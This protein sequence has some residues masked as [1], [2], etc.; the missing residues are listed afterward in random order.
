[1]HA[2]FSSPKKNSGFD[3]VTHAFVALNT[4]T[5]VLSMFIDKFLLPMLPWHLDVF[6][7]LLECWRSAQYQ[8]ILVFCASPS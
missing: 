7:V 1:M 4:I 3:L 6:V 2:T 8:N 5:L